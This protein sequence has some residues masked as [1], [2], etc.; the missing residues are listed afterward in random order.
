MLKAVS[1][2]DGEVNRSAPIRAKPSGSVSHKSLGRS[3]I[4][5]RSG[6]AELPVYVR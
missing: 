3:V 5:Q 6:Y 1:G 4:P 2:T